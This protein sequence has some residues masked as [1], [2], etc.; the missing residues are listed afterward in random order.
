MCGCEDGCFVDATMGQLR[1][2]M[3]FFVFLLTLATILQTIV[4]MVSEV[5]GAPDWFVNL[6]WA[7]GILCPILNTLSIIFF[8]HFVGR[9]KGLNNLWKTVGVVGLILIPLNV[10]YG[11][12]MF[13]F[14][15]VGLVNYS[16][17]TNILLVAFFII[18]FVEYM[19]VAMFY[20]IVFFAGLISALD[21]A[22][23]QEGES[24]DYATHPNF[25]NKIMTMY[26]IVIGELLN[27]IVF[28]LILFFVGVDTGVTSVN[29]SVYT[30]LFA[31]A[32]IGI[33]VT[34]IGLVRGD[35][36]KFILWGTHF[37]MTAGYIA[38]T[39]VWWILK[40]GPFVDALTWYAF[41]TTIVTMI[42]NLAH[43][44]YNALV[45]VCR[46]GGKEKGYNA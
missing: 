6:F 21:D 27:Y 20:G 12:T 29:V 11:I 13:V 30:A 45:I 38:Y 3:W 2:Y 15:I 46:D 7:Y 25:A 41:A 18:S 32:L 39:I 23:E 8:A 24:L 4:A 16:L 28:A 26:F 14:W 44:I 5:S 22:Y 1:F 35:P 37:F 9:I 17:S 43:A 42:I 33:R 36:G 19:I 31:A 10:I 34:N 40:G